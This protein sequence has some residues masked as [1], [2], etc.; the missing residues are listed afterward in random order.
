MI[1][2]A[3]LIDI[4]RMLLMCSVRYQIDPAL[5]KSAV[6]FSTALASFQNKTPPV[7]APD[8]GAQK[9]E[10]EELPGAWERAF[11]QDLNRRRT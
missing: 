11:G 2:L 4:M 9:V 6:D 10:K 7:F 1:R 8:L 5:L 3:S